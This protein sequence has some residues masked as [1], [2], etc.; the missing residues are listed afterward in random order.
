MRSDMKMYPFAGTLSII[1]VCLA[2]TVGLHAQTFTTIFTFDGRNTALPV[3]LT[4]G[5]DGKLYGTGDA[6]G[7]NGQRNPTPGDGTAFGMTTNGH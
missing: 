2:T 6:G 4:Q 5:N 3:A 1:L 7:L